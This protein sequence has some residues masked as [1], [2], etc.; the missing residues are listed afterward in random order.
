LT[1]DGTTLDGASVPTSWEQAP[2]PEPTDDPNVLSWDV[3]YGPPGDGTDDPGIYLHV[4]REAEPVAVNAARGVDVISLTRVNGDLAVFWSD[5]GGCVSW[6]RAGL[7][8]R[9]CGSQD[10]DRLVS[11]AEQVARVEPTDPRVQ[12]APD[13]FDTPMSDS[14]GGN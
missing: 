10:R 13:L 4:G 6:D 9:V 7:A 1:L 8:Y 11:L 2:L 5:M 12:E 14:T 3:E